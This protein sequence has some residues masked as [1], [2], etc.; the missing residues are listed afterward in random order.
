MDVR[1]KSQ[2]ASTLSS[3]GACH[4]VHTARGRTEKRRAI[5]LRRLRH[6]VSIAVAALLMAKVS[7]IYIRLNRVMVGGYYVASQNTGDLGMST[8][9]VDH[10]GWHGYLK[11]LFLSILISGTPMFS[12]K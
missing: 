8:N 12:K 6:A 3:G 10:F 9:V 11:N 4:S 2:T 1:H 7:A 5:L